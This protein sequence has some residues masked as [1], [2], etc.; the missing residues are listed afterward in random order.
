MVCLSPWRVRTVLAVVSLIWAATVRT[1]LAAEEPRSADTSFTT[2]VRPFIDNYCASCHN[3]DKASAELD[4]TKYREVAAVGA[5]FRQWELVADFVRKGEMPPADAKQPAEAER[6][7]VLAAIEHVLADE[8]AKVA[9][10]PGVVLSRRLTNAEYNHSIRDLTGFDLRPA[11]AFPVDPASGE[12]FRNTGEA[13][14]MSP[15]LFKKHY[16]AAQSV[17]DHLVFT[18]TGLVFAPYEAVTFADRLK[19]HEQALIRF[20]RERDVD[21]TAYLLAAWRWRH[22]W[23]VPADATLESWATNQRLS[24]RYLRSLW[25][26]LEAPAATPN[27]YLA[28]VRDA[29]KSLPTPPTSTPLATANDGS[30]PPGIDPRSAIRGIA[31]LIRQTSQRIGVRETPAIV[32][33]AGNGPVQHIDRRKKTAA[34]RDTHVDGLTSPRQFTRWEARRLKERPALAV[35]ISVASLPPLEP[36][37]NQTATQA[38]SATPTTSAKEK[39]YVIIKSPIFGGQSLNEGRPKRAEL[40]LSAMLKQHAPEQWERLGFGR[41]PAGLELGADS[42]AI[43]FGEAIEFSVPTA[44][45]DN[46]N[47]IGLFFDAEWQTAA[48]NSAAGA[49]VRVEEISMAVG[50]VTPATTATPATPANNKNLPAAKPLSPPQELMLVDSASGYADRLRTAASAFCQ[51]FPNR[52][53]QIDDTRGLSAGFHLIE[54]LF[55]DDQPLCKLV[56]TDAENREL[57]RRWDDL[58]FSTGLMEKMLRGFVFFERSER[59]FLKH[60]DFDSFKEEDPALV[61]DATLARFEQVYLARSGV[62]PDDPKASSHPVHLFFAEIRDGLKRRDRQWREARAV[63]RNQL[64]EFAERAFRRPLTEDERTSLARLF[65][66]IA[67]QPEFGVEQAT[68]AVVTSILVSPHFSCLID[69]AP[70]GDTIAP[71]S[72]LALASRLSYFLWASLPDAELLSVAKAGRLRDEATLRGQVRR[73]LADPKVEGFAREFFGQWLRYRDFATQESVDRAV[74]PQFDDALKEAMFEEPTRWA[75]HLIRTNGRVTDI[76]AGDATLVN[77]RLADHYGLPFRGGSDEWQ[78]VDGL[79]ARGRGGVLGMAVFLAANSQPQRTSPVKRGFW[80]VHTLLGEHIP[81]PPPNIAPLPPKETDSKGATIRQ[82]LAAHT[83]SES[84][85]TCHRRFDPVGLAMEGFDPIGRSR[86]KDLAGRPVDNAVRLPNGET[87]RGI[88]EFLTFLEAE[89]TEDYVKTLNRKLLGYALGRSLALSD[90]TLLERMSAVLN[91]NEFRFAPLMETV[92]LSSQFRNQRCRD[93]SVASFRR[94][95]PGE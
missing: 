8:A 78:L 17:A 95:N 47:E 81:A 36:Q 29:W 61:E 56:L 71:L 7:R 54:G 64:L 20:Y 40:G 94:T 73:M 18:P 57:N 85:A 48:G 32:S 74:F 59:N 31:D 72:D 5:D 21:Y 82:L 77:R 37:L 43:A 50:D 92:V 19:F 34:T 53:V 25:D 11:D 26:M 33:N 69:E 66:S 76:L 35:R 87:A 39:A 9:G 75:S 63:F 1:C 62:K 38:T 44:A 49:T 14:V 89:R 22:R 45:L 13:L 6:R 23:Q 79:R 41:H 55:R 15:N 90:K 46:R 24:P 16:A 10:D 80:V 27:P 52:F 86:L 91:K 30:F 60:P 65:D 12:G 4:L 83:E 28:P 93:F 84:C 68:R 51:L 67:D 88:P 2:V 42:L 70:A 58:Y 3:R